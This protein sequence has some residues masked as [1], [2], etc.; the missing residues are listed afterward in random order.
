VTWRV[1]AAS[2]VGTSHLDAE[3]PCQDSCWAQVHESPSGEAILSI[4]VCDGAGSASHAEMGADLAISTAVDFFLE[5]L[6]RGLDLTQSY[7]HECICAVRAAIAKEAEQNNLAI[8]D[9][10][11]TFLGLIST[12]T[13]S[14]AFQIGD[15][16]IVLD[17]G[18]GLIVAIPPMVGEYVNAT[19]FVTGDD[20]L[21]I[22]QVR[23]YSSPVQ[24]AAVFTDGLQALILDLS[25]S[26]PHAPFF[27]QQ[28]AVVAGTRPDQ[29]EELHQALRRFLA[30][31][32][33][34]S[35]TD[36]DKTLVLA[37]RAE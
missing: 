36:D 3:V 14:L 21:A 5:Q 24:R 33:V 35:K 30:S 1:V 17:V 34:N 12:S 31:P 10:A 19:Y 16:A 29:E 7:A 4:F 25:T 18:A 11:C 20:A 22:L 28:F 23:P 27:D 13:A 6:P 9:F 32:G 2:E 8:R 37:V 26:T 15:G